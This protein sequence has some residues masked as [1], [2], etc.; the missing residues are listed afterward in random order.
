MPVDS[1]R[2]KVTLWLCPPG[3]LL[4]QTHSPEKKRFF[5]C[6]QWQKPTDQIAVQG[7]G[8]MLESPVGGLSNLSR[9]SKPWF[10]LIRIRCTMLKQFLFCWERKGVGRRRERKR[11]REKGDYEIC[12]HDTSESLSDWSGGNLNLRRWESIALAGYTIGHA[13]HFVLMIMFSTIV[14]DE[15]NICMFFSRSQREE[16]VKLFLVND[17]LHD[18]LITWKQHEKS[19]CSITTE[20]SLFPPIIYPFTFTFLPPQFNPLLTGAQLR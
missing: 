19:T 10:K 2:Y 12:Q 6:V 18:H 11:K 1:A 4:K 8:K 3:N 13:I 17:R 20:Y 15:Q 7:Y 16:Q 9:W 14:T 5:P